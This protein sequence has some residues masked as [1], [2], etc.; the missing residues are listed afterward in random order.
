MCKREVKMMLTPGSCVRESAKPVIS[1]AELT[2]DREKLNQARL[3]VASVKDSY[4]AGGDISGA[5]LLNEVSL[6]LTDELAALDRKISEA[7]IIY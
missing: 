1:Q 2:S 5:R 3:L 6:A 4:F 7:G